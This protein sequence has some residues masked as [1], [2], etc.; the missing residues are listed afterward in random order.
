VPDDLDHRTGGKREKRCGQGTLIFPPT[1]F[2]PLH[3][4]DKHWSS[5]CA[6]L[7][8][9]IRAISHCLFVQL[10]ELGTLTFFTFSSR[11]TSPLR[12]RAPNGDSEVAPLLH[13][14]ALSLIKSAI[15]L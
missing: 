11:H 10:S 8:P 14:S 15:D 6:V 9:S 13:H 12:S 1:S 2:P 7:V 5:V 4:V 3:H